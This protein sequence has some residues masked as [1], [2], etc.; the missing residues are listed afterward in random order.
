M[1]I[2]EDDVWRLNPEIGGGRNGLRSEYARTGHLPKEIC[3]LIRKY[4][5]AVLQKLPFS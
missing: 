3:L 2:G 1:V 5:A 4:A